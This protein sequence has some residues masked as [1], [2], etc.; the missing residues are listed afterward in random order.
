MR[1]KHP[2]AASAIGLDALPQIASPK[3]RFLEIVIWG[4]QFLRSVFLGRYFWNRHL[5]HTSKLLARGTSPNN[6]PQMSI[7]VNRHLGDAIAGT[8]IWKSPC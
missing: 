2:G 7:F 4:P 8:A 3:W 6:V 1:S 5:G